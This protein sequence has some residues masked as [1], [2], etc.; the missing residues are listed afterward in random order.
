ML[1]QAPGPLLA[2][3]MRSQQHRDLP[4]QVG[5]LSRLGHHASVGGRHG[6]TGMGGAGGGGPGGGSGR[7]GGSVAGG[8]LG[9]AH[10]TASAHAVVAVAQAAS[11]SG[12]RRVIDPVSLRMG[13]PYEMAKFRPPQ[14]AELRDRKLTLFT[15]GACQLREPA[16]HKVFASKWVYHTAVAAEDSE[17]VEGQDVVELKHEVFEFCSEL[18]KVAFRTSLDANLNHDPEQPRMRLLDQAKETRGARKA[19]VRLHFL[20]FPSASPPSVR[21]LCTSAEDMLAAAMADASK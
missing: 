10:G 4:G 1:S 3:T 9:G 21:D 13:Y 8:H 15:S 20:L 7:G 18:C 19:G 14:Q 12:V 17:S 2:D 16:C 6:A 5:G 11:V